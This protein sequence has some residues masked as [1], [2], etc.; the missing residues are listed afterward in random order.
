MR[1]YA[2]LFL[3]LPPLLLLAGPLLGRAM[4]IPYGDAATARMD[5]VFWDAYCQDMPWKI[6]SRRLFRQGHVPLY[7]FGAFSGAPL[8]ANDQSAPLYPGNLP[9]WFLRP[10]AALALVLYLHLVLAGLG[11]FLLARRLSASM[12]GGLLAGVSYSLTGTVAAFLPHPQMTAAAALAPFMLY[13]VMAAAEG[14]GAPFAIAFGLSLLSGHLQYTLLTLLAVALI[15]LL[16]RAFRL[17]PFLGLGALIGA[18]QWLP[19]LAYLPETARKAVLAHG[20]FG[21]KHALPLRHLPA[22]VFPEAFGTPDTPIG[23]TPVNFRMYCIAIGIV[24][25]AILLS[26]K[27][28]RK[29]RLMLGIALAGLLLATGSPIYGLFQLL[30]GT[31]SLKPA[32]AILLVGLGMAVAA[33]I[34]L[35][36]LKPRG[37][38]FAGLLLLASLLPALRAGAAGIVAGPF[39]RSLAVVALLV[40]CAWRKPRLLSAAAVIACTFELLLLARSMDPPRPVVTP[41]PETA[42]TAKLREV[43]RRFSS[44]IFRRLIPES[45]MALG[46]E[47]ARGTD[48]FIPLRYH[49]LASALDPASDDMVRVKLARGL[50]FPIHAMLAPIVLAPGAARARQP[51]LEPIPGFTMAFRDRR[52][53]PAALFPKAPRSVSSANE[54][55]D[56]VVSKRFRPRIDAVVEGQVPDGPPDARI[57]SRH[58]L[59]NG[60]DLSVAVRSASLLLLANGYQPGFVTRGTLGAYPV[61]PADGV[62]MGVVLPA[63]E[64]S[65]KVRYEPASYRIGLFLSLFGICLTTILL[66]SRPRE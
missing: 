56:A 17:L 33:G 27:P 36:K 66:V 49:R 7:S 34:S 29:A 58:L 59:P 38:L 4:L 6:E 65:V 8:L 16:R 45:A 54:A 42:L 15:A 57:L 61:M 10:D 39:L 30:P 9:Y 43:G 44:P 13:G 60:I 35:E 63:G 53:P 11:A 1:R 64:T 26:G 20:L 14:S 55:L 40:I 21:Y 22:L 25:V 62:F 41:Y 47:D 50:R 31:S 51:Y 19:T 37:A 24:P 12:A 28:A 32:R 18:V 2:P 46:L 3:L 23:K 52:A 48:S 5:A